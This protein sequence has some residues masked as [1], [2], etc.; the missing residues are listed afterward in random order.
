M[1]KIMELAAAARERNVALFEKR[2]AK[3]LEPYKRRIA[4]LEGFLEEAVK[5]GDY[6]AAELE[7]SE[8]ALAESEAAL[9]ESEAHVS[10]LQSQLK[11]FEAKAAKTTKPDKPRRK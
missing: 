11:A 8:A 9:A 7:K 4:E 3:L 10:S 1:D 6:L 2:N 5:R